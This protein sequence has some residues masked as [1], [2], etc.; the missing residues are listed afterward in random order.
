[1]K[2]DYV[3]IIVI[4]KWFFFNEAFFR[5]LKLQHHSKNV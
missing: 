1:M 4:L 3:L 2:I 5:D